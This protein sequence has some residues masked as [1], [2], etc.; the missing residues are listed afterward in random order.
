[1]PDSK[2]SC[3]KEGCSQV[4][5]GG[6]GYCARHYAQWKRGELPKARFKSCRAEGCHKRATDR[7]RCAEHLARDYPGKRSAEVSAPTAETSS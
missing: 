5:G 7:G 2:A 6:K 1:M 4:A 3:R